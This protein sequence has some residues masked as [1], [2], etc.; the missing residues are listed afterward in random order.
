M[1]LKADENIPARVIELLRQYGHDVSTVADQDL[2]GARDRALAEA[3][4]SEDRILITVDRGFGDVRVY[5]PG[6]H[7]GIFVLHARELRP[8]VLLMLVATFLGEH[9]LDD[10]SGCNVVIEPGALRVRRPPL[11]S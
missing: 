1:R 4:V 5:P 7:P 6:T 3:A 9:A 10:F 8:S 11:Q 2:V